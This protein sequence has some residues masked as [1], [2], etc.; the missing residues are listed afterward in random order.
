MPA[1]RHHWRNDR[2]ETLVELVVAIAILGVAGVAILAGLQM[3]V[4]ASDQHRRHAES[5]SHVRS[6]AEAI[7]QSVDTN[8]GFKTCGNAGSYAS[9]TVP[10]LPSGYTPTVAS[11]RK[12]NGS[13]WVACTGNDDAHGTQQL[14]LRV[15]SLGD[16]GHRVVETLAVVVRKPCNAPATTVDLP[17][18]G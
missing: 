15:T 9:L 16:A 8:A 3:S 1:R 6:F 12:W 4:R 18:S 7:Q 14:E 5:G 10:G 17:C 13:A 11:V 2:G